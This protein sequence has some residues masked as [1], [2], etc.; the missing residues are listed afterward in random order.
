MGGGRS[1][2]I[3]SPSPNLTLRTP[4][5]P[6]MIEAQLTPD[7]LKAT[8]RLLKDYRPARGAIACLE[9]Q[10]GRLDS[11]FNQLCAQKLG[12]PGVADAPAG[13][14]QAALEGL[15]PNLCQD[16]ALCSQITAYEKSFAKGDALKR[17]IPA[18]VALSDMPL[19]QELGT[20]LVLYVLKVGLADFCQHG[21][22]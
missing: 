10:A 1:V 3:R 2:P 15:R 18:I 5:N 11:S 22:G 9:Q 16:E 4:R 19:D 21:A 7:E 14:W 8:A 13:F 12:V 17:L 20:L 6:W